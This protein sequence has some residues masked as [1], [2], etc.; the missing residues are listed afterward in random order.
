MVVKLHHIYFPEDLVGGSVLDS[1]RQVTSV[2]E[3]SKFRCLDGTSFNCASDGGL[4]NWLRFR[5]V[6][7][8]RFASDTCSF[9]KSSYI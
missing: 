9:L 3:T 6:K 4:D 2:V 5:L 7:R 8:E 1:N